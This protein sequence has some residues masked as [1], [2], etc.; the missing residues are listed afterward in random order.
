[1]ATF[2]SQNHN[3]KINQNSRLT[4]REK[5]DSA[6]SRKKKG[7][8]VFTYRFS[9]LPILGNESSRCGLAVDYERLLVVLSLWIEQA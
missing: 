8:H 6:N 5:N 3:K 7:A 4:P 2:H 1:M 9:A